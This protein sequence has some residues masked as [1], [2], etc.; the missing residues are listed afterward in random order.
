MAGLNSS[1]RIRSFTVKNRIALPPLVICG[2]HREGRVN[3]AVLDH[4]EALARGGNGTIIVEATCVRPE[5]RLAG[6][7]L[8]LWEDGQIGGMARIAEC[9]L[10]Y[11]ALLL[12]QIH[13]ASKQ[14][15]P[16]DVKQVGP[17]EYVNHDGQHRALTTAEV[18]RIRD[19]FIDAAARAEKAGFSGVEL[20]GAHGYLLCAFMNPTYNRRDDRY[21]ELTLLPRE[22]IAGIRQRTGKD[23][24]V[25][26]RIGLDNP[27]IETGVANS[28]ALEAAGVDLLN[29]SH[30]MGR[31]GKLP[32]PEGFPFSELAWL[33]CEAKKHLTIPVIAVGGLDKPGLA[34]KLIEGGYSDFAAVGR[35]QLVDPEWAGKTLAGRPVQPCLNCKI[36]CRWFIKHE[37]CPGKRISCNS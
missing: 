21:G 36:G 4:Y 17:S 34:A 9:V 23:F 25:T 37:K 32:V 28:R 10:P 14:G 15:E 5:G 24:L 2:L 13:Y 26:C 27:D 33:G 1:I 29:V 16:D 7:Q 3:E 6:P 20:H 22:I 30:G 31:E 12:V 18:E 35:G 11:G 8:G 19:G